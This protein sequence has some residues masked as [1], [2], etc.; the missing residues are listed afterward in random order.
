M[1]KMVQYNKNIKCIWSIVTIVYKNLKNDE[2]ILDEFRIC[3]FFQEFKYRY[4][5]NHVAFYAPGHVPAVDINQAV[6]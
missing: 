1:R 5:V 3:L 6:K 4:C 2:I